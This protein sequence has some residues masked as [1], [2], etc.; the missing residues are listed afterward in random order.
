MALGLDVKWAKIRGGF[1]YQWIGYWINLE[2][3]RV[4]ISQKR[5]ACAVQWLTEILEGKPTEADFDSGLGRLSFVCGAVAYDRPYLAPLYSH[6]AA[7]RKRTGLKVKTSSLPPYVRFVLEHLR[8]RLA[9]SKEI[10]CSLGQVATTSALERFRTDAKAEGDLVTVGG[11][12]TNDGWGRS[13]AHSDAKWFYVHLTRKNAP[14]AFCKGE[15]FRT[16]ASLELLGS[17]LGIMLL[18]DGD[19]DPELRCTARISVGGITDNAGNRFAVA[20]LLTTNCPLAAFVSELAVQLE[21]RGILFEM[22]WV[23]REQNAEADAI[24]NGQTEWLNP[25]NQLATNLEK[26]PFAVLQPL[27]KKGEE[28]YKNVDL[29]NTQGGADA[30]RRKELLKVRDPWD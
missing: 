23:P 29:V 27:L 6:A 28:F 26:L 2:A 9:Q 10:H 19:E 8:S 22:T 1:Q 20:R 14:W 15:P 5:Q 30:T 7:V 16:I 24:T 13:I 18:L 4:G 17:L 25:Q 11:Y 3:Y 21:Q 12:Q